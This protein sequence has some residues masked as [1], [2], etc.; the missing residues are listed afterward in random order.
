[1]VGSSTISFT[2]G[3]VVTFQDTA[4]RGQAR[5][6][7][8]VQIGVSRI[9]AGSSELRE[10]IDGGIDAREIARSWEPSVGVFSKTR[11]RFLLY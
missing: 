2:T 11:E 1:M 7:L 3:S 9:L 4:S 8:A 10:Q 6:R 5:K